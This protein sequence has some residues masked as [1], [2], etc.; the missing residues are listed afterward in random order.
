MSPGQ[1]IDDEKKGVTKEEFKQLLSEHFRLMNLDTVSIAKDALKPIEEI[2]DEADI[3]LDN[4]LAKQ[5][6][7]HDPCHSFMQ[8]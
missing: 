4:H 8:R 5:K 3:M 1:P 6:T 2:F 7:N